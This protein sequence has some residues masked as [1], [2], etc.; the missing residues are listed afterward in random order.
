MTLWPF[1]P[2][3]RP[4]PHF[5]EKHHKPPL[6][7]SLQQPDLQQDHH[8]GILLPSSLQQPDHQRDRHLLAQ[9]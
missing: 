1:H 3:R 6:L 9:V 7:V 2:A 8:H 4:H 5:E